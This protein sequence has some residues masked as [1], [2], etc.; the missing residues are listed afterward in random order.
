MY[1]RVSLT[2]ILTCAFAVPLGLSQRA[3]AIDRSW[4]GGGDGT[5]WLS[6][7]NWSANFVPSA[8][9]NERAVIGTTGANTP[10]GIGLLSANVAF[11]STPVANDDKQS[12]GLVLGREPTSSGS[13]TISGGTMSH[14][15]TAQAASAGANGAVYLGLFNNGSSTIPGGIGHL[16]MTGGELDATGMDVEGETVAGDRS[17]VALSGSSIVKLGPT[18]NIYN[19][20]TAG[21]GDDDLTFGRNLTVTGPNVNFSNTG[22]LRFLSPSTFTEQITSATSHSPLKIA[23]TAGNTAGN[24][25]LAGTL[26]VNFSGL[27][28]NPS[29][30][31]TWNLID[32][33]GNL[34]GNFSNAA[35]NSEVTVTGLPQA[36]AVG[37]A[38]KLKTATGGT[39]GKLLQLVQE[40]QL[41]L[42]VN[43]D[44]GELSI[45]N[46]FGGAINMEGYEIRSPLG[47]LLSTYKGIS[48]APAG[49]TGWVKAPLNSN[50]GLAEL[51][52]FGS[53]AMAPIPALTLGTGAQKGFD[54]LAVASNIANFGTD[55]EDVQFFYATSDGIIPG[56]VEY[57]GTKFENNLVLRVNPNTGQAFI[58]NDSLVTLK[59]DGYS[60]LSSTNSLNGAGWSGL[61]AGGGWAQT[62]PTS[63]ALSETNL[64]SSTTLAPGASAAIGTIG[65]FTSAAAQAGL[66]LQFALSQ[67]LSGPAGDYNHNGVVDAADYVIWRKTDGSPAGYTAWRTN[68]GLT[69]GGAE[70][71]FRV[72]SIVFDTSAG[73]GAGIGLSSVPEPGTGWLFVLG[74]GGVLVLGSRRSASSR[75]QPVSAQACPRISQQRGGDGA[76]SNQRGRFLMAMIGVSLALAGAVPAGATTG[77][78]PL[79]NFDFELPGPL[80]TKVLAFDPAGNPVAGIIPNWT[81]SGPGVEDFGH[82]GTIGD[83]GTEGSGNLPEFGN[84][85][86]LSTKDGIAYQTATGP[87]ISNPP[88]NQTYKFGFDAHD[89]F[90]IDGAGAQLSNAAEL[91]ARFYYGAA[92]TTLTTFVIHPTGTTSHFEMLIGHNDPLL[93]PAAIGQTLGVEFDTTSAQFNA[94]V[95]HSWVGIDNVVLETTGVLAGDLNGDGLVNSSDYTNLRN[96]LQVHTPFEANGDL[97]NDNIVDLDDFRI[98]KTLILA[99][100]SGAGAGSG[101]TSGGTVPEPS[102]GVLV[103]LAISAISMLGLRRRHTSTRALSVAV[104]SAIAVAATIATASTSFAT[105][106]AYDPFLVGATPAN[107]E[108]AATWLDPTAAAGGGQNPTIGIP[109]TPSFFNGGWTRRTN[110]DAPRASVQATGLSYFGTPSQGGSAYVD[111]VSATGPES[112]T[113]TDARIGR[114]LL[115]PW[116]SATTGTFYVSWEAN[117]GALQTGVTDMGYRGL[118]FYGATTLPD[119]GDQDYSVEYNTFFS[120]TNLPISQRNPANSRL[121]LRVPG[122]GNDQI[123]NNSPVSFNSD[124][125][126]HLIVFKFDLTTAAGGDTLSV[127]LDPITTLEPGVGSESASIA[128]LDIQIGTIG[129]GMYGGAGSIGLS[130]DELRI[131]NT[132]A[133]V[134]PPNLPVPGDTNGDLLIDHNDFTTILDNFHRT[135]VSGP[136]A[137]DIALANGNVGID[138]RVSLGDFWLWKRRYEATHPG[139]GASLE[140]SIPEPSS[141]I[142]ICVVMMI[143]VG[144]TTRRSSPCRR[145]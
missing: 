46:P 74:F 116:T 13:L 15:S 118:E 71:T 58:K 12:G 49:D 32:Y 123:L 111:R 7:A 44:T 67:G 10:A 136:S 99:A 104:P 45:R 89:I 126:T 87:T 142:L 66:S 76:M 114:S 90:T 18:L 141:L 9:F 84:D 20:A 52:E 51:R 85:L 27:A 57:V 117:F 33:G 100:G 54:K 30:G 137:G 50:T 1:S 59:F 41:V 127:F 60:V 82:V 106:L 93:V 25:T 88:V 134:L 42:R 39:N 3:S 65:A 138:G 21:I 48:G 121:A 47:S 109:P 107:G 110:N 102:T 130:V 92:R 64:T 131:G 122:L 29:V 73:A 112:A 26:A 31:Q 14:A 97:N 34:T 115:N 75:W 140:A 144:S 78:M 80:G 55:G 16:T 68:F 143:A 133:D 69:G 23:K 139:A 124:G 95:A 56:D 43:R 63:G 70:S 83:S 2:L 28:T 105:V 98:L 77:G 135:G 8:H 38:F 19:S 86:I 17:S 125:A 132:F 128:G 11:S 129:F 145:G 4:D 79:S 6:S 113:S 24:V 62:S 61:G 91:T 96:N 40:A 72:G 120:D 5:T 81:F 35:I 94:N 37:S 36:P 119:S 103:M 108:Y 53:L 101:A 22:N